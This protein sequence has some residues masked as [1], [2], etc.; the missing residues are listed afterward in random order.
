MFKTFLNTNGF[1]LVELIEHEFICA[2]KDVNANV[3]LL[4]AEVNVNNGCI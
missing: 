4:F 2:A 3:V 1:H